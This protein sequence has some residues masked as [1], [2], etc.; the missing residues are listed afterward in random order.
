[1]DGTE[2]VKRKIINMEGVGEERRKEGRCVW[3]VR[4]GGK[5]SG[6]RSRRETGNKREGKEGRREREGR[7]YSLKTSLANYL[8]SLVIVVVIVMVFLNVDYLCVC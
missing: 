8:M 3:G 2:S 5:G 4:D 7:S 6:W 1:M